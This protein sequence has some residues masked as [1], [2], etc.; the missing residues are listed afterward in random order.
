M[1]NP[2]CATRGLPQKWV[3]FG[4]GKEEHYKENRARA[5]RYGASFPVHARYYCTSQ[6][7]ERDSK[8]A[9]ALKDQPDYAQNLGRNQV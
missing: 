9:E 8:T 4:H 3:T 1:L 5:V 2:F 7:S 6:S